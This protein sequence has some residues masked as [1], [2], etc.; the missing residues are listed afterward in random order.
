MSVT[1]STIAGNGADQ[2]GFGGS[3]ARIDLRQ[4]TPEVTRLGRN[5]GVAVDQ[6]GRIY[7]A[8][9]TNSVIGRIAAP[10]GWTMQPL[11]EVLTTP[12][13]G[14]PWRFYSPSAQAVSSYYATTVDGASAVHWTVTKPDARTVLYLEPSIVA[15]AAGHGSIMVTGRGQV[16]LDYYNGALDTLSP[17][18][19]LSDTPQALTQ[20]KVFTGD[21]LQFKV[22]SPVVQDSLELVGWNASLTQ[23]QLTGDTV[24]VAGRMNDAGYS[25]DGHAAGNAQLRYPGGVAV[26]GTG[27]VYVAD[28]FNNRIRVIRTDGRI[29]TLAGDGEA[30]Y[31]GEGQARRARFNYPTGVAVDRTG[32]VYVADTYNNRVRCISPQGRIRTVAGTGK[33]GFSGDGGTATA[34]ELN[35]PQGVEACDGAVYVADSYNNRIRRIDANGRISTVAGTGDPGFSGDNGPAA[36]ATLRTPYDVAVRA[37]GD[38]Y[39]ADTLNN[40]IRVVRGGTISTVAGTG[41]FGSTGRNGGAATAAQLSEPLSVAV[42][43]NSGDVYVGESSQAVLRIVGAG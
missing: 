31:D 23:S 41:Q 6:Q 42:D 9:T 10:A 19:T 27:N 18:L 33:P 40:R 24:A 35:H 3:A 43:D 8:A 11:G 32:N 7:V 17:T 29:D 16:C 14:L 21:T 12:T 37:N 30:G 13:G 5:Q 1:I 36:A 20:D 34:A 15:G 25:G 22:R 2:G 28:T 4:P 38:L 26:D 39:I